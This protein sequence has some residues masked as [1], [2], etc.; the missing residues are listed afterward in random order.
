M[1]VIP[2]RLTGLVGRTDPAENSSSGLPGLHPPL[3]LLPSRLLPE[4]GGPA[5]LMLQAEPLKRTRLVRCWGS[6]WGWGCP[7]MLIIAELYN[8]FVFL[9]H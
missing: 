4:Q 7:P 3:Q 6:G 5:S 1:D 2:A 9:C 8:V